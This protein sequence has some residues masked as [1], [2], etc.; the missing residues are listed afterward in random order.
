MHRTP[1]IKHEKWKIWKWKNMK[2]KKKQKMKKEIKCVNDICQ[3][4]SIYAISKSIKT[5]WNISIM[6]LDSKIIRCRYLRAGSM[7]TSLSNKRKAPG[8]RASRRSLTLEKKLF[9]KCYYKMLLQ[10]VILR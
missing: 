10:N 6:I 9:T 4:L 2:N 5:L 3:S 8:P 1:E 7:W